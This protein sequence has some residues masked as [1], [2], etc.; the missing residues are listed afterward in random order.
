M[1]Q[2]GKSSEISQAAE[3]DGV[4]GGEELQDAEGGDAVLDDGE[5]EEEV[6]DYAVEDGEDVAGY[7]AE[8]FASWDGDVLGDGADEEG[9]VGR[10]ACD[11][12]VVMFTQVERTVKI[13]TRD[14]TER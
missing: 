1:R 6:G 10:Y 11:M 5:L 12:L 4:D 13:R 14:A 7:R 8:A 2:G 9:N 3:L